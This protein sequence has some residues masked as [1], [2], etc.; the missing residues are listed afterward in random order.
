MWFVDCSCEM[1]MRTCMYMRAEENATYWKKCHVCSQ[2]R[3]SLLWNKKCL[4]LMY[5]LISSIHTCTLSHAH[6][7][8]HTY[9][10]LPTP[11]RTD[12]LLLCKRPTFLLDPP[13][14]V[15]LTLV[16]LATEW[17]RQ[18]HIMATSSPVLFPAAARFHPYQLDK[19]SDSHVTDRQGLGWYWQLAYDP[20][21]QPFKHCMLLTRGTWHAASLAQSRAWQ[22][23]TC[24][25]W[26]VGIEL[27]NII[28]VANAFTSLALH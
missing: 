14:S 26:Y 4:P 20:N 18:P 22:L 24:S 10:H 13:T 11:H 21:I 1:W 23:Q 16:T 28:E 8:P 2:L 5:S 25:E 6:V 15:C 3:L 27:S 7:T 19:V 9:S 12:S 17:N